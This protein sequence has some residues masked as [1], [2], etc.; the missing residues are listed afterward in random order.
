MLPQIIAFAVTSGLAKKAW[1]RYRD[2][3]R[4]RQPLT[5]ITEV[6]ARPAASE[7]KR[8]AGKKTAGRKS[9]GPSA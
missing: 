3:R 4:R 9:E 7:P 2:D 6:V 1:D 8:G 5:D